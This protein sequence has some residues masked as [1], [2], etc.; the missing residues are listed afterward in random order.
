MLDRR[1]KLW[2]FA[3]HFERMR[4]RVCVRVVSCGFLH[5]RPCVCVREREAET[6]AVA[7]MHSA[8]GAA[9]RVLM[10]PEFLLDYPQMEIR[11][12]N[13]A[14]AVLIGDGSDLRPPPSARPWL[15]V[16]VSF[17][18]LPAWHQMKRG[19]DPVV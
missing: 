9:S 13:V 4:A 11:E 14:A 17:M 2:V 18:I 10:A 8:C 5:P 7:V 1:W 19:G 6:E 16:A 3:A 15:H 12:E